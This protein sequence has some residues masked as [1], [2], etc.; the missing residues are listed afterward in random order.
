MTMSNWP[1]T[2]RIFQRQQKV[3]DAIQRLDH[4]I[5]LIEEDAER[6][7]SHS[8]L[9]LLEALHAIRIIVAEGK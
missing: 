6:L 1:D 4:A 5:A 8:L 7:H 2:D 9:S 3:A